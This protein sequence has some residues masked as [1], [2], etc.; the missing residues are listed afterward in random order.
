M[1]FAALLACVGVM[2]AEGL[3]VGQRYRLKNVASGLYMQ[4]MGNG[5]NLKLQ[6]EQYSVTQFFYLEAGVDDNAGKYYLKTTFN[7]TTS[8]VQASG[9]DAKVTG[10]SNDKTP[11][12]ISLVDGTTDVYTLD[13]TVTSY[14]GKIGANSG[15]T[16]VGTPLYCNKSGA[17]AQWQFEAVETPVACTFD[18]EKT[19]R[20]K[21]EYCGLY[22]E[23][24][25]PTQ[26]DGEGAFRFKNKST[27][28]GQKFKFE[29]AEGDSK[30]YLKTIDGDNTYYVHA[31][32]WDF[33]AGATADT[34]FEVALVG[35]E[36]AIY[37]L[38][39][40]VA[41][42]KGFAGNDK[43]AVDGTYIY[44]NCPQSKN[45]VWSFEEVTDVFVDVT[46]IYK[47]GETELKRETVNS[48]V[49]TPYALNLP[50]PY[51]TQLEGTVTAAGEVTVECYEALPFEYAASV[52][53]ITKWYY[54]Q[55]KSNAKKYIQ[56]VV[57]ETESYIEWVDAEKTEGETESYLWAFVGNMTDGFKMVNNT[58]LAIKSTGSDNPVLASVKEATAWVPA[59][60]KV[61][62][63]QYFCFKYPNGG[64]YMNA[65]GDKIAHWGDNDEGS[66]FNV[67]E[68]ETYT[69]NYT[70]TYELN[71]QTH[72]LGNSSATLCVGCPYPA[73]SAPFGYSAE[74]PAKKVLADD[75][76]TLVC[77]DNLPFEYAATVGDI[78]CWYYMQMHSNNWKY[79]KRDDTALT[80]ADTQVDEANKGS[81]AWAFVGNPIEGFKVV[82]NAAG[83]DFALLA[84]G[85]NADAV[86]LTA[87]ADATPLLVK[88]SNQ[89]K[90]DFC[91][92]PVGDDKHYIN[93]TSG[94]VKHWGN[95]DAGSTIKVSETVITLD[96]ALELLI[97][98]YEAKNLVGSANPGEYSIATVEALDAAIAVAKKVTNATEKDIEDLTAAY[99]AL[100]V[101]PV[102]AGLYRIVSANS[103]F[104]EA[105][106]ITCYAKD[107]YYGQHHY[108]AWAPVNVN[109]PLQYWTLEANGDGT[110]NIKAA[111]E[112]N[113]ITSATSLSSTSTAA[114]FT[115]L[116]NAQ[117]NITLKDDSN[118]LHCQGW[119]WGTPGAGLTTWGGGVDSPSAWK[120]I[121]VT[122]APEFTYEL[123]VNEGGYASL[124]LGFNA[125][126]P[127]G[128]TCYTVKVEGNVA[129]LTE[130]EAQV[131]PA[132]TPVIVSA[133]PTTYYF[134]SVN[135][136]PNAVNVVNEL[137]G[138]LYPKHIAADAYILANGG[139]GI[140]FY[141]AA[142]NKDE[143]TA[144]L[145]NANKAYL[146]APAGAAAPMFSINRGEGTTSIDNSQLTID[147]AKLTIY[148][149]T[150]RRVEKMEKGI[151][152]VNGKKVVIK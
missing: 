109:D 147:N 42:Y 25:N 57:T 28:A 50:W 5:T 18:P 146:L 27:N 33:Y 107:T 97:K 22:M 34:P 23:L 135:E 122:E 128:V 113:Y 88:P 144:F 56:S 112:G 139:N 52:E 106:G 96:R 127:A 76:C 140:G 121:A 89:N 125:A 95:P 133:E 102:V 66:T 51:A 58:G 118:P 71:E 54:V 111:Y 11:F 10:T 142:L 2:N 39:Q 104:T 91:L 62:G 138:T 47:C 114:T 82:N 126:I 7:G 152:I 65:Q 48:L 141:K 17:N 75:D 72:T 55:M 92:L 12:T 132:N 77:T 60:S 150:G 49:G 69:I 110:F 29:A 143:N 16:S 116:G 15:E 79:I 43:D 87:Y 38:N 53:E 117:F 103:E 134:K 73:T 26:K 85:I 13:Q 119:N 3:E 137:A 84:T 131:L 6:E 145:N 124:M 115:A 67:V 36:T 149:L 21:S 1:L 24:V 61:A 70:Y 37:S 105:K 100:A 151:Y 9:W 129:K 46:Y 86:T 68:A 35:D 80:W 83:K 81:Y 74:T 4:N 32:G 40:Q 14:T 148:D 20:I 41:A 90:V 98:E 99:N 45:T 8:Y 94:T 44:N 136:T 93:A 108:S 30:Y 123:T 120:L 78:K 101:N 59:Q 130:I 31:E 64:S 63:S 19:Y